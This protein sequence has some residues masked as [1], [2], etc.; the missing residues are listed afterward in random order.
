MMGDILL[1]GVRMDFLEKNLEDIIFEAAQTKDG[2]IAL[3]ERGLEFPIEGKLY[4]QVNLGGYGIADLINVH[5]ETSPIPGTKN[6]FRELNVE[7]IELK[8]GEIKQ[9]ALNQSCRYAKAVRILAKMCSKNI[10]N[11]NVHITLIGSS[12][13]DSSDTSFVYLY[14]EMEEFVDIYKY[15]YKF[16][17]IEFEYITHD[18]VKTNSNFPKDLISALHE[19]GIRTLKSIL[20]RR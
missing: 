11:I 5:I 3:R 15:S 19:P 17:G 7:I 14:N 9:S 1:K 2:R 8:R 18:W 16:D 6:T 13:D 12:V 10:D 4:R 20:T